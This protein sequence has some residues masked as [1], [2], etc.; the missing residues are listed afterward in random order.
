MPVA[1]FTPPVSPLVLSH[2][3]T[4]I[5][6]LA[7]SLA[8]AVAC[9]PMTA[10]S[11]SHERE[12]RDGVRQRK[13]DKTAVTQANL[14]HFCS[15]VVCLRPGQTHVVVRRLVSP[16][17]LCR[18]CRLSSLSHARL[19]PMQRPMWSKRHSLLRVRR[20]IGI[21][22]RVRIAHRARCRPVPD[23]SVLSVAD[24]QSHFV[25]C[26][27]FPCFCVSFFAYYFC[28]CFCLLCF[29]SASCLVCP[30]LL[31][32]PCCRCI[33]PTRVAARSLF[34]LSFP[35]C[36]FPLCRSMLCR[37]VLCRCAI[38]HHVLCL[39]F[40]YS[41]FLCHSLYFLISPSV[42]LSPSPSVFTFV[43]FCVL[44]LCPY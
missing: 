31:S 38:L 30:F 18:L 20:F 17:N 29:L 27:S 19:R 40:L 14:C 13:R 26:L 25:P 9:Q 5:Y 10:L 15:C 33:H 3:H 2:P 4:H 21:N 37:F 32:F 34:L 7:R 44:S 35:C 1:G 41:F 23:T 36:I 16:D 28:P 11:L 42:T 8:R 22:R 12:F 39:S 43:S 6:S 24:A